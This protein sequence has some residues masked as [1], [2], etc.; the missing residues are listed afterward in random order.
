M[1]IGPRTDLAW[2]LVEIQ[3]RAKSKARPNLAKEFIFVGRDYN[4]AEGIERI[5]SE[6]RKA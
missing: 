1:P 3:R 2:A 5:Y 6:K 4:S